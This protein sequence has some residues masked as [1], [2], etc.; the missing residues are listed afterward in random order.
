MGFIRDIVKTADQSDVIAAEVKEALSILMTL[1][2]SKSSV[3][4]TEIES[5]LLTGRASDTLTVP[6]TKVLQSK[7]EYRGITVT[8]TDVIGEI[9]KSLQTLFVGDAQL[10][11]GITKIVDSAITLLMG[12]GKGEETEIR[13]YTVVAEYPAI[14]RYDFAFWCRNIEADNIFS[15]MQNALSCVAYKSAVDVTKLDFNTFLAIYQPILVVAYGEDPKKLE[16]MITQAENIY[17]RF[18]NITPNSSLRGEDKIAVA[19]TPKILGIRSDE[20]EK[21]YAS[22]APF[23]TRFKKKEK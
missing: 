9:S 7:N 17:K 22:I 10:L 1:A 23:I 20:L 8:S 5:D 3:F 19:A 14:V 11:E 12:A 21:K 6:I 13:I 18:I 16:E 4:K 2:E 15:Q